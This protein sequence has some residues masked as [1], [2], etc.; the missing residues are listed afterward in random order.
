MKFVET[1]LPGV[2]VIEPDVHRDGRGFFLE[3]YHTRKYAEGGIPATFV[4]DNHSRSVRGTLRG[5]HAQRRRPQGKLVRVLQGEI[6]DV[7]VD[8][9]RGSPTFGRWIG[10]NLSA[11][12]FRQCYIPPNF[13]HGFCVT[14]DWAESEYKCTDFYDPADEI[15]LLWNDPDLGIGWPVTA[16]L[17]SEKDRAAQPLTA[18]MDRL[19]AYR[20]DAQ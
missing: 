16:P 17:L 10:V 20:P 9:R 18:L 5:L 3:T 8:I 7:V 6:F 11:E 1:E 13:A 14:S 15:R 19:P 2:I 12:N 4:Q